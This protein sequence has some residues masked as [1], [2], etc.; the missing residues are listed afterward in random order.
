MVLS[1][2]V[3]FVVFLSSSFVVAS[4]VFSFREKKVQ[5]VMTKATG[6]KH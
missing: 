3:P 1:F 6:G 4:I 2:L 5:Q